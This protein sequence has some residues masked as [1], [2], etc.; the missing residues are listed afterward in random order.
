MATRAVLSIA[1]VNWSEP[2][3]RALLLAALS[4]L[5]KLKPW[6]MNTRI[7]QGILRKV[8]RDRVFVKLF[9]RLIIASHLGK[10][11][12]LWKFLLALSPPASNLSNKR[13]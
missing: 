11:T 5:W 12:A 9:H 13:V 2:E 1:V 7:F 4:H 3:N 10:C 8:L 6:V